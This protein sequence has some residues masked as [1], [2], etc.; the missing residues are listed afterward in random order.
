MLTAQT[1]QAR[2]YTPL[3]IKTYEEHMARQRRL[4]RAS[5]PLPLPPPEEPPEEPPPPPPPV[6]RPLAPIPVEPMPEMEMHPRITLATIQVVICGE[7]GITHAEMLS[8]QKL[9]RG[10]SFPRQIAFYLAC[11]LSG[12]SL[13]V[14]GKHFG[15]D[16]STILHGRKK[17]AARICHDLD[18]K[19]EI[20]ALQEKCLTVAAFEMSRFSDDNWER[21]DREE[22][23]RAEAR[24]DPRQMSLFR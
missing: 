3:Q 19:A 15:R 9:R 13:P 21:K 7:Y 24:R 17:I 5:E 18:F 4:R 22:E 14:I 10:I 1:I 8:P 11:R 12:H 2:G 6:S 23:E 16:H 20:E